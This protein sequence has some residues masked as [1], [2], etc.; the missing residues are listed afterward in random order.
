MDYTNNYSMKD[1]LLFFEFLVDTKN[2]SNILMINTKVLIFL[3]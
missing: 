2:R 3:I 1:N